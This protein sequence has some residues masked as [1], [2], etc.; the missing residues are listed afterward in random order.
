MNNNFEILRKELIE[1]TQCNSSF[2]YNEQL[3]KFRVES[4]EQDNNLMIQMRQMWLKMNEM[5]NEINYLKGKTGV[6]HTWCQTGR[7]VRNDQPCH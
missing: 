2:C 3:S 1:K 4:H 7:N 6:F 5:S